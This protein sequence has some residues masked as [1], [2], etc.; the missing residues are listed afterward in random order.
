MSAEITDRAFVFPIYSGLFFLLKYGNLV[1]P[2]E[3]PSYE[4]DLVANFVNETKK[5]GDPVHYGRALAMQGETYHRQGKYEEAIQSHIEL[6]RVYDVEKHHALVVASYA[7]D[8]CA[9][10]FGLSANCFM[11]LGRVDEAL[12]LVDYIITYLMPKMNLKNVHNSIVTIY[13][14]IWILKD[15]NRAER[16][17]EI[18]LK[19]V[20]EP[21]REYFGEDG[22]TPFL[23]TFRGIETLFG[24][25]FYMEGTAD[26]L[27]ERYFEWALDLSNL[28]WKMSIDIAIGAIARSPMSINAEIC[29]RLS[30]L[31]DDPEKRMKLIENGMKLAKQAIS[32]CD[33]SDGSSKLLTTYCQIK[34]VYD[35]LEKLT[36]NQS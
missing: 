35:E 28:E 14:A 6:K 18:F 22:K 20:L 33:G 21:F 23:P 27:D 8:R 3:Q 24:I 15:N 25:V 16:A 9:Q 12:E 19:F 30:K 31:T 10:N 32:G 7:S 1:D 29:L 36:T 11:R 26:S 17:L 13:P 34:P 4:V 5:H 2:S